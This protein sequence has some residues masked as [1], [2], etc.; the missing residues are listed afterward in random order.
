MKFL[1]FHESLHL[2]L[3]SLIAFFLYHRFKTLKLVLVAFLVIIL[4]D[5]DHLFDYFLYVFSSNN[6]S[7]PFS[8]NYF[9]GSSKVFVLL[10]GW[11]WSLPLWLISRKIGKRKKLVGLEW[12][13]TL[14]YLGHLLIDQLSYT[15]NPLAYFLTFRLLTGFDLTK[16]NGLP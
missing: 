5:A 15:S 8:V 4:L 10:H 9:Q 3:T 2:L 16:F 7:H 11:E 14:S 1:L 12:A 6:F 13:V